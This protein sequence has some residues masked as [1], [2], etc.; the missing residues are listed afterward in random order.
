VVSVVLLN[1]QFHLLGEEREER[2]RVRGHHPSR[3]R[4]LGLCEGEFGVTT[5]VYRADTEVGSSEIDRQVDALH[6][7]ISNGTT[8]LFSVFGAN[9]F[10]SIR[11]TSDVCGN[12]GHRLAV[13]LKA[14]V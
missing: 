13:V 10:R 9:R 11:D 7:D 2:V 5:Q 6:P 3:D 1:E 4:R 12:H 8:L 14:N